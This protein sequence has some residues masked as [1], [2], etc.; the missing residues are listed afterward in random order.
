[1]F[2]TSRSILFYNDY[3]AFIQENHNENYWN[4]V[5]AFVSIDVSG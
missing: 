4:I 5:V 3:E 2:P 1:M